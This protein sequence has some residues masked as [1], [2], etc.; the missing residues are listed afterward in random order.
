M[1]INDDPD[2][3]NKPADPSASATVPSVTKIRDYDDFVEEIGEFRLWQK[4]ICFLL[5][6]PAAA[7]GVHVLMYSFTGL[8]PDKYRSDW[9]TMQSYLF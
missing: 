7:G 8:S 9:E 3:K 1:P 4:L 2:N 5:W 6:F